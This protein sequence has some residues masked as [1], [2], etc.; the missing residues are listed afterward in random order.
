M[1]IRFHDRVEPLLCPSKEKA[2]LVYMHLQKNYHEA[3]SLKKLSFLFSIRPDV[4]SREFKKQYGTGPLTF[5]R[6]RRVEE[7][8]RLL[9]ERNFTIKEVCYQV[10]FSN[11][12]AFCKV[13]K[14]LTRRSPQAYRQNT[15]ML[16]PLGPS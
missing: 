6:A 10:G 15:F 14:R 12:Q 4:L 5:L 13:F 9:C 2:I 3:F 8:R 1:A 16:Y 7:A 11:P